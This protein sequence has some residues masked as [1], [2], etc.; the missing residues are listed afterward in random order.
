M[1]LWAAVE[2][3]SEI[4]ACEQAVVISEFRFGSLWR[5]RNRMK[6]ENTQ[7][8]GIL[9]ETKWLFSVQIYNGKRFFENVQFRNVHNIY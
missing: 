4:N 8:K 1:P 3:I 7:F 6:Y 2:R 9:W 5:K